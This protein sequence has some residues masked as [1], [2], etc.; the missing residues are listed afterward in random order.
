MAVAE[1]DFGIGADI[2]QQHHLILAMRP[3]GERGGGGIGA[4]VASDAGQ[5]VDAGACIHRQAD[6]GR[7]QMHSTGDGK[8]ERSAAKLGRVDAE[9]EMMH[10][11]IANEDGV[12]NILARHAAIGAD[13][14]DQSVQGFAH[15]VGHGLAAVRVHHHVGNAAHQILAEADLWVGGAGRC[16]GSAREQRRQVHG[17]RRRADIAGDAV[18][19]VLQAG[20]ERDEAR[21]LAVLIAMDGG[22]YLPFALA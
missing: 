14:V 8:C 12:Q 10:D 7:F 16:D 1:H 20:I 17:D 13:L 21:A 5:H 3:L 4:D 11:R 6:L 19:L 18:G 2:D 22:G 15:R 9:K